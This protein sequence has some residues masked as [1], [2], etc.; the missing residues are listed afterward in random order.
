MIYG[1]YIHTKKI[2]LD[3]ISLLTSCYYMNDLILKKFGDGRKSYTGQSTMTTQL[4]SE[5]NVLMY[6]LPQFNKLYHEIRNFF[7]E[8]CVDE[9]EYYIQSWLNIY[10]KGE[11]INWHRHWP[12]EMK[13]WHGFYC[14]D[15]EP[16]SGTTYRIPFIREE[17]FV[18]SENNLLVISR[19]DGD[20]HKSSEWPFEDRPRIT[21]AFDIVPMEFIRN[22]EWLNHWIPL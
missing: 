22:D 16:D 5:Y 4:F 19:S 7:K 12:K 11:F 15:V 9:K 1:D 14:V 6:A 18:P 20:S 10:K 13:T 2:N 8:L 17:V 21:I 3:T